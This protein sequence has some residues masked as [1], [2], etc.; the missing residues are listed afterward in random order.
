MAPFEK[1]TI[2]KKTQNHWK[3]I[4]FVKNEWWNPEY[5]VGGRFFLNNLVGF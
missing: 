4:N 3:I 5:N 2:T 1:T